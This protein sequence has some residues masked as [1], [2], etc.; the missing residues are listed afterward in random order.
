MAERDVQ[1]SIGAKIDQALRALN[2]IS[3]ETYKIGHSMERM[4]Q[5][6]G[7]VFDP[8]FKALLSGFAAVSAA[9]GGLATA[10]LRVGGDFETQMALVQ[11]VAGASAEE[12]ELLNE[13]ARALGKELPISASDAASAMYSLASAGMSTQE[14]L[15]S[16]DGVV[17]ISISQQYGLAE[18]ADLVVSTLNGMGLAADQTT[19]VVDVFSNAIGTSQ[20]TMQKLADSMRYVAPLA[21]NLGISLEELAAAMGVLADTG[22]RGEQVGT[23]LRSFLSTIITQTGRPADMIK[24]LGIEVYD[25]QGKFRNLVDILRDFSEAELSASEITAIFGKEAS[26]GA[27]TLIKM[28][29]TLAEYEEKMHTAG[30]TQEQLNLL[31]SQ[32]KQRLA[33]LKSS[34]QEFLITVFDGIKERAGAA[35]DSMAALVDETSK[36]AKETDIFGKVVGEFFGE[37]VGGIPSIEDFRE[38]LYSI[39]VEKLAENFGKFGEAINKLVDGISAVAS[40]VPWGTIFEHLDKITQIVLYG[41]IAGKGLKLAGGIGKLIAAF[42][43]L[44]KILTSAKIAGSLGGIVVAAKALS[45]ALFGPVGLI[46]GLTAL[47][48]YMSRDTEAPRG[49]ILGYEWDKSFLKQIKDI[50]EGSRTMSQE[51]ARTIEDL[52][53]KSSEGSAA[54]AE[55]LASDIRKWAIIAQEGAEA[56]SRVWDNETTVAEQILKLHGDEMQ[57]II[58]KNGEKAIEGFQKEFSRL[59]AGMAKIMNNVLSEV[60]AGMKKASE[61]MVQPVDPVIGTMGDA[62]IQ[63]V[64]DIEIMRDNAK[65]AMASFNVDSETAAETFKQNV[66]DRAEEVASGL[67]TEMEDPQMRNAFINALRTLGERA[68]NDLL[69]AIADSMDK[70][71]QEILSVEDRLKNALA[72]A[73]EQFGGEGWE[74]TLIS[75]N[76]KEKVYQ[77]TNGV[78]YLF[79][80]IQDAS[81][82]TENA[83]NWADAIDANAMTN[84]IKNSLESLIPSS[85][86]IGTNVGNGLYGG[87][88]NGIDRVVRYF[89]EKLAN[90]E[91]NITVNYTENRSGGGSVSREMAAEL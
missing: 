50:K 64:Q 85:Q 18:S 52:R 22:A 91:A 55:G 21:G 14:I 8:A 26:S 69:G 56:V 12:L 11:G 31:M 59:P 51:L 61:A 36:W 28:V 84:K 81:Q 44:G 19:R 39:D 90:L 86:N 70:V 29:D 24:Q 65:R 4:G 30:R 45:G 88:K 41:W 34:W 35:A 62:L 67:V 37:L 9:A 83:M 33:A 10:A 6:M 63:F 58:E 27:M 76:E 57:A 53:A 49:G 77:L 74:S 75:E 40:K 43:G 87:A 60:Q 25:T 23:W 79:R 13:K 68:G 54:P 82:K 71:E 7:R 66:L 20:L 47:T 38:K 72:Q 2:T 1:I 78:A 73:Q 32:F 17:A 5:R 42:G 16:L 80:T 89:N 15:D 48:L 46:A 3:K